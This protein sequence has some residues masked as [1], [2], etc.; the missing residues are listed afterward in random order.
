ML[1][2]ICPTCG[3]FGL[4]DAACGSCGTR[5]DELAVSP[6]IASEQ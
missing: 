1:D 3:R 2:F 4:E 6:T 5:A